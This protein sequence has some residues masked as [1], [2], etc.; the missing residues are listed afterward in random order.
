MIKK[1]AI[2]LD[3][4]LLKELDAWASNSYMERSAFIRMAVNHYIDYL[5]RKKRLEKYA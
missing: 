2:S 4:R 1:V 5:K 3:E